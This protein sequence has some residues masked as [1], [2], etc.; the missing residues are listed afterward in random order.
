MSEQHANWWAVRVLVLVRRLAS[1][2]AL[3]GALR[4][5]HRT[6]CRAAEICRSAV[7]EPGQ[8]FSDA[9][10]VLGI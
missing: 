1:V 6:A 2:H 8:V 3:C 5:M 7:S 10:P 4:W 9:G